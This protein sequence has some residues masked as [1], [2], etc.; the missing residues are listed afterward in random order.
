MDEELLQCSDEDDVCYAK[1]TLIV[2]NTTAISLGY[3]EVSKGCGQR[4][5]FEAF[6]KDKAT[7]NS[8]REC[9]TTRVIKSNRVINNLFE[10]G[11]SIPVLSNAT[12]SGTSTSTQEELCICEGSKCNSGQNQT[13]N[14]FWI[15]IFIL[16]RGKFSKIF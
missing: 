11:S 8:E 10:D 5:S 9:F 12:S 7:F 15:I 1:L 4:A 16:Y 13:F 6:Y 14:A 2:S 3:T